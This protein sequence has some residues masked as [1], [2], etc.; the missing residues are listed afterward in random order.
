MF[1][2]KYIIDNKVFKYLPIN[3][4]CN[5]LSLE[6]IFISVPKN[7]LKNISEVF[8]SCNLEINRFIFP[9]Y[10]MGIYLLNKI[11]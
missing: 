4:F 3:I 9:S 6:N 11:S 1:N 2:F 8:N 7:V 5:Q 10:A